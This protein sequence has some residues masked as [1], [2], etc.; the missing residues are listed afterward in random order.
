MIVFES[1]LGMNDT[2]DHANDLTIEGAV[3]LMNKVGQTFEQNVKN[4]NEKKKDKN[5]SNNWIKLFD[6]FNKLVDDENDDNVSNRVRLLIKN[7]FSNRES[8]WL[9][10]QDLNQGPKTKSQVQ[11][12]VEDKHLK[13][14]QAR[15]RRGYDDHHDN[16]RRG[17]RKND[18]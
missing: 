12:E 5:K 10:T 1:L 7:M 14:Q 9:K 4:A 8:G 15:D 3:N 18:S 6:E 11:K 13:E 17:H 2:N 16:S